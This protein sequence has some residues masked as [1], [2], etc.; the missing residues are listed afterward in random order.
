M[1]QGNSNKTQV[2]KIVGTDQCEAHV[3][4]AVEKAL[5]IYINGKEFATMVCT[6]S[7][8]KELAVGFLCSE[9]IINHLDEIKKITFDQ[10]QGLVWVETSSERTLSEDLFLKRYI[11]SCCGKGKSTF[12][13]AND[14]RLAQKVESQLKIPVQKVSEYINLLEEGS[15]LFH[16]T[17]GVHGGALASEGKL[18]YQAVDIGRH[19]V[20][21]KLYG[22]AFLE[23]VNLSQKIIVFSGRISSEIVIKTA[24][25]GCPILVGVSAP[26]DLALRL[27]EE[28]GITVIGFARKNCMNVYTHRERV[29]VA[30]AET[31]FEV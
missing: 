15:E 12:Y 7:Q 30:E 13:F 19:N 20:L 31:T 24:K 11:T 6:P 10:R 3:H 2:V 9:G 14:A 25:M 1:D 18:D 22:Q 21:D 8:G 4:I 29:L 23:K 17:G 16:L 26:T 27:A 28:L 5:T